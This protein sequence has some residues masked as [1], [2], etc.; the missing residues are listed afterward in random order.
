MMDV[1]GPNFEDLPYQHSTLE[2]PTASHMADYCGHR[3]VT[4]I[5]F[6]GIHV[7]SGIYCADFG[8]LSSQAN[9]LSISKVLK[10]KI[11]PSC[12]FMPPSSANVSLQRRLWLLDW[13]MLARLQS[14]AARAL[15]EGK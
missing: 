12:V 14:S 4:D 10:K 1:L 13:P 15:G 7:P 2:R 9:N 8:H 11:H 6:E 3:H 5:H